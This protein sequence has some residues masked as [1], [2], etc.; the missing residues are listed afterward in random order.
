MALG[1]YIDGEIVLTR[2]SQSGHEQI[3]AG[4]LASIEAMR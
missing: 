4:L 2:L 3:I 1:L